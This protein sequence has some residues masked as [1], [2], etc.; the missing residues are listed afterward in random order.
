LPSVALTGDLGAGDGQ[1]PRRVSEKISEAL[2]I[3]TDVAAADVSAV[4]FA[5]GPVAGLVAAHGNRKLPKKLRYLED[6][7]KS[8]G[9][10]LTRLEAGEQ[11]EAEAELIDHGLDVAAESRTDVQVDMCAAIVA[12][13]LRAERITVGQAHVF[14]S[15]LR[16]LEPEHVTALR[17]IATLRNIGGDVLRFPT[18]GGIPAVSFN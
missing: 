5:G 3:A 1:Y 17:E 6:L 14:L 13:A 7:V 16:D 18:R 15:L 8:L 10:R 11:S 9:E 12:A 4:P 2:V